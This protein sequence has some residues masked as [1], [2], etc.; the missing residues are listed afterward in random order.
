MRFRLLSLL[1]LL[2]AHAVMAHESPVSA[3]YARLYT[4]QMLV[5]NY[6]Q[7][8]T[9]PIQLYDVPA[10]VGASVVAQVLATRMPGD[11]ALHALL[12][13]QAGVQTLDLADGLDVERT[14][15]A[16]D[17]STWALVAVGGHKFWTLPTALYRLVTVAAE[18]TSPNDF[19]Q[20]CLTWERCGRPSPQ[21]MAEIQR[22]KDKP[23][24][25]VTSPYTVV[26]V[27][28]GATGRYYRLQ[29]IGDVA[30]RLSLKLPLRVW[31]PV[32]SKDGKPTASFVP[33]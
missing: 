31:I 30:Q 1:V 11:K 17:G 33:C 12:T 20:V 18:S 24:D 2:G 22:Y 10:T 3:P 4:T 16:A 13:S 21:F 28:S 5:G 8:V 23:F 29:L 27:E 7:L 19:S 15:E 6:E 32:L 14:L 9:T 26:G 25:A